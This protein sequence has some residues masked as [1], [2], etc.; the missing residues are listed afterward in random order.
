MFQASSITVTASFRKM[1]Q[2]QKI[3]STLNN[4][5]SGIESDTVRKTKLLIFG[6][7][8]LKKSIILGLRQSLKTSR[9]SKIEYEPEIRKSGQK[10]RLEKQRNAETGSQ[11]GSEGK[12]VEIDGNFELERKARQI[13]NREGPNLF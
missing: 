6:D 9:I 12:E 10:F 13:Q 11:A 2:D 1:K 7:K 4:E 3:A 5:D 8:F